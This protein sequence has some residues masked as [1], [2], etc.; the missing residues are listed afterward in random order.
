MSERDT[1]Y[2]LL[3]QVDA[4]AFVRLDLRVGRVV[5]AT[6]ND[7]ARR[8]AIRLQVDFGPLGVRLSS[9]QITR[10]YKPTD[11]LGRLVVAVVNLPAK[12]IADVRSE[13]LVL[14]AVDGDDVILLRPDAEVS[15]GARIG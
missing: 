13:V 14:G 11:L 7:R 10:R 6:V 9:A 4:G 12:Q 1:P 3:P 5:R 2:G 15:L 8:P